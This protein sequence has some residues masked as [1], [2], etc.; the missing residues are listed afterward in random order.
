MV[1]ALLG[2]VPEGAP[3]VPFQGLVERVRPHLPADVCTSGVSVSWS[4]SAVKLDLEARGALRGPTG[5]PRRLLRTRCR[6]VALGWA[7][8]RTS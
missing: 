6:A 8:L 7:A 4:L 5:S 2:V 1:A 3:G